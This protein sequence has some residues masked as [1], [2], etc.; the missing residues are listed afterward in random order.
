MSTARKQPFYIADNFL[1]REVTRSDTA[2]KH[3]I[4]NNPSA[5]GW[6]NAYRLAY[7]AAQPARTYIEQKVF[8][9]DPEAIRPIWKINSW[10]RSPKVNALVG[11]S[12]TSDHLKCLAIDYRVAGLTTR[13]VFK[14]IYREMQG[15]PV[16]QLILEFPEQDW[17]WLHLSTGAIGEDLTNRPPER[18]WLVASKNEHGQTIYTYYEDTPYADD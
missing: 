10:Y 17:S 2:R 12:A 18:T 1:A 15:L 16:K 3:G 5:G 7:R 4:K 14:I 6:R 8:E 13:E 9:A 11:S